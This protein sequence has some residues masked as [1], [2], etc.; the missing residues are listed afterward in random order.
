[1]AEKSKFIKKWTI[2][3]NEWL[4]ET[5][6]KKLFKN[7]NDD[8]V[9]LIGMMIQQRIGFKKIIQF[10]RDKEN[11]E[12]Y[13][14]REHVKYESGFNKLSTGPLS[15]REAEQFLKIAKRRLAR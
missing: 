12:K 14:F 13:R 4:P 6:R 5:T 9:E 8:I 10:L 2:D 1:M 7:Q 3:S 11:N 15:R